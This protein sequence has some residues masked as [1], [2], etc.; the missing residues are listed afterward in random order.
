MKQINILLTFIIVL[1]FCNQKTYAQAGTLDPTFGDGGIV[2]IDS[3]TYNNKSLLQ[4]DGKI[5]LFSSTGILDRFNY[6]GTYDNSFGNNGR[7]T[8]T[9]DG[10]V[11]DAN[12]NFV[13]Q[14]DSKI[15]YTGV[16]Y[17]S[18]G[19]IDACTFRCNSDGSIDSSF[20]ING[21]DIIEID[22]LNLIRGIVV[23]TDGKIVVAGDVRKEYNDQYRT[24][25]YRLMPDGGLDS[26]FGVNGIVINHY[27][28]ETTSV[29]FLLTSDGK[30]ILGSNN[31]I[32]GSHP[33]YQ[34]EKFNS[35]GNVD[36]GFGNNGSAKFIFGEGQS[37]DWN[38]KMI[39]LVLQIDGK[40]VCAGMSG[41]GNEDMA[42][43]RFNQ[44]GLIDNNFGENGSVINQYLNY[45]SRI[46]DLTLQSDGKILTSG[47]AARFSYTQKPILLIQYLENGHLD[48]QFGN[49]GMTVTLTDTLSASA[50]SVHILNDGKILLTGAQTGPKILLARY[51]GDNVLASNFK[52]IKA[53][54]NKDAITITWQTLNEDGTKSFTVERS[55]NANDYVDINT[56]PAKGV[57]S[58]YSY[59]DKN[60]LDGI[61]YYRIKENTANG[62]NTFSPVVKVVFNDNGVISLYP[63][64]AKN[65]VTVKGLNKNTT[66]TIRI[67]DM[68]GREISKQYFSQS[69]TA[70]LNIR[71]LAQ[72]SYFVLVEQ[73]GKITKLRIVKE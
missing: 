14:N 36:A 72:G 61:S 33:Y 43:C 49:N 68:N 59:T 32:L 21:L 26:T 66:A 45:D 56:I 64:P 38:T 20:G 30:F 67:T 55:M 2:I 69:S 47:Y 40:I 63:N 4:E 27:A 5:L 37:G 39:T 35:D 23:Q 22:K 48:S 3:F 53:T 71:T 28:D 13:I 52:D 9:F 17:Q 19:N 18:N 24:F 42:L 7:I 65:T 58:K 16:Y 50:S 70:M 15:I 25:I 60:P 41:K 31:N 11:G 62:T 73:N 46:L 51:N 34:L 44:N 8:H 29:G 54:Q 57:A 6:D 10:K 12:N 1:L